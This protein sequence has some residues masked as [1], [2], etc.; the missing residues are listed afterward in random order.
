MASPEAIAAV[1]TYLQKTLGETIPA[2]ELDGWDDVL[3]PIRDDDVLIEAVRQVVR[4]TKYRKLPAPG[5]IYQAA[6]EIL[7]RRFPSP[8][9][10]WQRAR[11][12]ELTAGPV[13]TA[14]ERIGAGTMRMLQEGDSATRARFLEFYA[15][16]VDAAVLEQMKHPERRQEALPPIDAGDLEALPI[17][18]GT[19]GQREAMYGEPRVVPEGAEVKI[20]NVRELIRRIEA[21]EGDIEELRGG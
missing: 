8:G 17:Y 18:E 7:R 9:E 11:R 12:G 1:A 13:A 14:F 10:A 21:G 19:P 2:A 20:P 16:A 15:E 6:M 4:T 5:A 3:A